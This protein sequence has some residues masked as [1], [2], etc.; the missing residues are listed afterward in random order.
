MPSLAVNW[1]N[2]M[3]VGFSGSSASNYV[4]AFYS[5]LKADGTPLAQ[6]VLIQAGSA[7]Y[8]PPSARWG[9]YSFTSVDPSDNQTLWTVQSYATST[10]GYFW[11]DWIVSIRPGP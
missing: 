3:V 1:A 4:S 6:P 7:Y 10:S 2:V 8:V 5:G 9:D 11:S